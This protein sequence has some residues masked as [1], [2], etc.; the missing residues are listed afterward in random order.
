[1]A[2]MGDISDIGAADLLYLLGLK[3]QSG[4]LELAAN[5]DRVVVT[6]ML[7]RLS[8][9]TSTDPSLRL[10][11][12]LIKFGFLSPDELRRVLL[13]QEQTGGDHLGKVLL[14]NGVIKS[15]QLDRCIEEQ[16]VE[17]LSTVIAAEA[18]TFVFTTGEVVE[19]SPGQSTLNVDRIMI[20]ATRRTDEVVRN[21]TTMP[22]IEASL[23]IGPELDALAETL[24]DAE[25]FVA[26]ALQSGPASVSVIADR[27]SMD[28]TDLWSVVVSMRQRRLLVA[29]EPATATPRPA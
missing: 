6:L 8:S 3:R 11:G 29:A 1:M 2:F 4:R 9:I 23:M 13:V 19:S 7:G 21:K 16:C 12:M 24:S 26:A 27:L 14:D 28:R 17:I 5:G 22:D 25:V 10:G 15:E 18:G 20:E